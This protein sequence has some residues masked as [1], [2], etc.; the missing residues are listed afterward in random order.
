[1][2]MNTTWREQFNRE[3]IALRGITQERADLIH[4]ER[5][6]DIRVMLLARQIILEEKLLALT[7]WK[8]HTPPRS[9]VAGSL[10]AA[11]LLSATCMQPLYQVIDQVQSVFIPLLYKTPVDMRD[12]IGSFNKGNL[13]AGLRRS[14]HGELSIG[15]YEL[16]AIP[17]LMDEFGIQISIIDLQEQL[18]QHRHCVQSLEEQVVYVAQLQ[19]ARAGK[20]AANGPS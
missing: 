6:Q 8:Y 16:D 10:E 7:D 14:Q 11:L 9:G 15:Y 19:A 2:N 5:Q 18:E 17:R 12:P 4:K 1:M 13:I 20:G 3:A